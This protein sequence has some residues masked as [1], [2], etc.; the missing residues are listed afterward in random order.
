MR[1]GEEREKINGGDGGRPDMS[2]NSKI[3][4]EL[5]TKYTGM[6]PTFSDL[7]LL[8]RE[9]GRG[10]WYAVFKYPTSVFTEA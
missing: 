2:T 6:K 8:W 7:Y 10:R 4:W 3:T 5:R 9:A 1:G